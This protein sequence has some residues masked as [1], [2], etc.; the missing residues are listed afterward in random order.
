MPYLPSFFKSPIAIAIFVIP[1]TDI[2]H[3]VIYIIIFFVV[4]LFFWDLKKIKS[5]MEIEPRALKSAGGFG[6][7]YDFELKRVE[8][9]LPSALFFDI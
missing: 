1:I 8:K 5:D 6:Q 9:R 4:K 7:K 2:S 3:I